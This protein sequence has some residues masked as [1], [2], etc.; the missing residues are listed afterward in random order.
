M[1][2]A[3]SEALDRRAVPWLF[4]AALVTTL[5]HF[6]HQPEWLSAFASLI[7]VWGG[8]LWWRATRLPGRWVLALLVV[9]GCAG[10]LLQFRTPVSYTHL[11]VYKRQPPTPPKLRPSVV[12]W[13][14]CENP[15]ANY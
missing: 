11:D 8:W 4:V 6:E 5:P 14:A 12:R 13:P 7:F 3:A 15:S 2:T 1:S 10:I 9:I